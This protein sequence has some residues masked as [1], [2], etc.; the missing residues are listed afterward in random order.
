M[1]AMIHEGQPH[2][3]RKYLIGL[4]VSVDTIN[5]GR[6][7]ETPSWQAI[8]QHGRTFFRLDSI[9]ESTRQKYKLDEDLVVTNIRG[10]V[11]REL[12]RV[13]VSDLDFFK[14][15]DYDIPA[16]VCQIYQKQAGWFRLLS[17]LK[18][19]NNA[20]WLNQNGEWV[21]LDAF[22]NT[23]SVWETALLAM[24]GDGLV[25]HFKATTWKG[26]WNRV[27]KWKK[28]L[29]EENQLLSL[30]HGSYGNENSKVIGHSA[31]KLID[32]STGE[33]MPF[34]A[35]EAI[36][37]NSYM[38][39]GK[40]NKL[41][42]EEV[43]K[44]YLIKIQEIGLKPVT[45][46]T[47]CNHLGKFSTAFNTS[48]ERHGLSHFHEKH[49]SY[50]PSSKPMN[51]NVLVA[52]DGSSVKMFYKYKDKSGKWKRAN[53]YSMRIV[54]LHSTCIIGFSLSKTETTDSVKEAIKMAVRAGKG[55]VF[56]E[57]LSDNGSAFTSAESK[58]LIEQ[59]SA[60]R[61]TISITK[62]SRN[63]VVLHHSNKQSNPAEA[64]VKYLSSKARRFENWIAVGMN[65]KSLDN[66][67]NADYAL[68]IEQMP[69]FEELREQF[70]ELVA[71]FNNEKRDGKTRFE[72]YE[73]GFATDCDQISE[74]TERYL[75]ASYR[76]HATVDRGFVKIKSKLYELPNYGELMPK[77]DKYGKRLKV[78]VS[79]DFTKA[80]L[81]SEDDVYLF[82]APL[83]NRTVKATSEHT[84]ETASALQHH[85]TRKEELEQQADEFTDQVAQTSEI[86][87]ERYE[88]SAKY[89]GGKAK[90]ATNAIAQ[91]R[92]L[93]GTKLEKPKVPPPPEEDDLDEL[94]N[95]YNV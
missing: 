26:L 92:F 28:A 91:Q 30:V 70:I 81:Y 20:V 84:K 19:R 3:A 5:D 8:K 82:T 9:P 78:I 89:L 83:T 18:K 95:Y 58:Q 33:Q 37:Y 44:E 14:R 65:S 88:L 47:V 1:N 63:G 59:V 25:K 40:P 31:N 71:L 38:N 11:L 86:L 45:F 66:Q 64:F 12:V 34:G 60:K 16:S 75:F 35:H 21:R 85:Q 56:G 67:T 2:I 90:E 22:N 6:K 53:A 79:E 13:K 42:R 80:D 39:I 49:N 76:S 87:E 93:R 73:Q 24:Q 62:K 57:F 68:S 17:T 61:R 77:L 41:T 74:V 15:L 55:R 51:S 32:R 54:D 27:N 52:S 10:Q 46:Q 72:R 48:M 23:Q 36:I 50:V 43:Y 4:G 94:E 7:S 69:T 29:P